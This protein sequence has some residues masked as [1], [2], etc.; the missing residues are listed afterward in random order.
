MITFSAVN[1][2]NTWLYFFNKMASSHKRN[3]YARKWDEKYDSD[4]YRP[5]N[6]FS[7]S[8]PIVNFRMR[9]EYKFLIQ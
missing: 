7:K 5:P 9:G 8:M 4:V 1:V 6:S 2:Q 3:Y